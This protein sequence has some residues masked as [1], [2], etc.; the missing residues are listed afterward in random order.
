MW[1]EGSITIDGVELN[2]QAKVFQEPSKFGIGGG[3]ISKLVVT[4]ELYDGSGHFESV[5]LQYDQGWVHKSDD[6]ITEKALNYI[7]NLYN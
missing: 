2:Y 6:A 5:I 4:R 3:K 7:L 1:K